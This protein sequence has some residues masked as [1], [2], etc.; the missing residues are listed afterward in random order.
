[1]KEIII[2]CSA[3]P[4]GRP[5]TAADIHL[6]HKNRKPVPF[7]GIGYHWVIRIDGGVEAGRPEYWTGSHARGHNRNSI[8]ICLIGTDEYSPEQWFALERLVGE[9]R[10]RYPHASIIGHNEVSNKTCP[11]F[12]VQD[13]LRSLDE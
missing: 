4:N 7:D 5:H 1:M 13:W 6:W 3:T 11:G 2:H 12:N 9:L 8:G 10:T